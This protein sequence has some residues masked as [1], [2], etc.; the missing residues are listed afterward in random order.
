[1]PASTTP[2]SVALAE[3]LAVGQRS[4]YDVVQSYVGWLEANV[5]YDLDAPLPDAG[6]DAVHDFLFDTRLGFCEQIAS[7]L[8]VMLRT[9]GVPARLVTGYLPGTRDRIAGVFEVRA[10]D[11]HAWV[12]VWFPESGWQAF[13]PTASVPLSADSEIGSLGADLAAGAGRY[14]E[15]NAGEVAL[16]SLL[17]VAGAVGWQFVRLVR[18]RRRRGRWG[19]LQDRYARLAADRGAPAAA[20]NPARARSWAASSAQPYRSLFHSSR[21][22]DISG[23]Q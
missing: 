10:S 15:R 21:G 22:P 7:A 11:A 1:M 3:E 14:V 4:T 17:V 2:E 5:E 23:W 13:D 20:S 6:E 18:H 16:A 9:Q 19:L 8:T 12:E